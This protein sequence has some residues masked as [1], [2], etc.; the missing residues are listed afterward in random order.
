MNML[1]K[2]ILMSGVLYTTITLGNIE[3]NAEAAAL[4]KEEIQIENSNN[5]DG[6]INLLSYPV[7]SDDVPGGVSTHTLYETH[8]YVITIEEQNKVSTLA[9]IVA[10]LSAA[11][12][13]KLG[14]VAGSTLY[15][16]WDGKMT[17]D[18][19]LTGKLGAQYDIRA[20]TAVYKSKNPTSTYWG[21]GIITLKKMSTNKTIS[22]KKIIIGK[23]G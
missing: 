10:S 8:T 15:N 22:S 6:I 12:L 2:V 4:E 23:T 3:N 19:L 18:D 17:L 20:N 11:K 14:I 21:Y 13:G 16:I 5:Y 7:V 9:G 1:S